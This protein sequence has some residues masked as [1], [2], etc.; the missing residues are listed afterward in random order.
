MQTGPIAIN[1]QQYPFGAY[2]QGSPQSST[3]EEIDFDL[4]R[5]FKTFTA[6]IGVIDTSPANCSAEIQVITDGTTVVDST[7]S[8]GQ[9]K[10]LSLNVS[11]VL[12][13][14]IVVVN[15]NGYQ[16]YG[17]LGNPNVAP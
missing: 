15:S 1:G 7:F 14:Q 10:D 13:L 6:R 2:G 16:C 17:G 9:S 3:P 12:R 11:G 8:L 4:S 5:S